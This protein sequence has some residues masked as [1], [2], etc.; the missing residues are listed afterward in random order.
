MHALRDSV[1]PAG[2]VQAHPLVLSAAYLSILGHAMWLWA[3]QLASR[4]ASEREREWE[5]E[6]ERATI[7]ISERAESAC[8][9]E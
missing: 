1:R 6:S 7:A 4:Q 5:R 9:C 8:V 3:P 2:A